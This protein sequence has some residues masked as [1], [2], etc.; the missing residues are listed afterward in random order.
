[1]SSRA[2]KCCP[3]RESQRQR[4]GLDLDLNS[5][6]PIEIPDSEGPLVQDLA[7]NLFIPATQPQTQPP[8]MIDVEAIEDDVILTSP[9]AFAEV[10]ILFPPFFSL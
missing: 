1:M 7:Q 5:I 2:A 9:R 6:P 10:L 3:L 4:A 8:I